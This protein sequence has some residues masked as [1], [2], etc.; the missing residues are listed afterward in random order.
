MGEAKVT[1]TY[2]FDGAESKNL[3]MGSGVQPVVTLCCGAS[4]LA[5]AEAT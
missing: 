3:M 2:K 5:P 1:L 4:P